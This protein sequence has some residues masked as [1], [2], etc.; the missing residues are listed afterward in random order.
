MAEPIV[1]IYPITRQDLR[2]LVIV[3]DPSYPRGE[4]AK[5]LDVSKEHV[6]VHWLCGSR[7]EKWRIHGQD[8]GYTKNQFIVSDTFQLSNT[9]F[10]PTK[11]QQQLLNR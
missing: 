2:K 1:P 10:L 3:N 9:Q 4:V 11:F 7:T 6:H 8:K 5:L